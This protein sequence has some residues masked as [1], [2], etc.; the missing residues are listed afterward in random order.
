MNPRIILVGSMLMIV[1]IGT[2]LMCEASP[3]KS[4]DHPSST[5][6]QTYF[7][8]L[9]GTRAS[10]W[11]ARF[12]REYAAT[13]LEAMEEPPLPREESRGDTKTYRLLI[14]R[15]VN[16]QTVVNLSLAEDRCTLVRKTLDG[17]AAL[18]ISGETEEILEFEAGDLRA[19][20]VPCPFNKAK[21]IEERFKLA[22]TLPDSLPP[23]SMVDGQL[24]VLESSATDDEYNVRIIWEPREPALQELVDAL[25]LSSE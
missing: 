1:L 13:I 19:E 16:E 23:P 9:R 6:G 18:A 8:E 7:G 14:S 2:T 3:P 12:Y 10:A 17:F 22:I 24:W 11:Q 20:T 21:E 25:S 5:R 15:S 4:P